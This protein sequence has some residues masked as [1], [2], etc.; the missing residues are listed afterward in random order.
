MSNDVVQRIRQAHL[1]TRMS[2][3]F[4]RDRMDAMDILR[5]HCDD[6]ELNQKI[7][8][9]CVQVIRLRILG[10][11]SFLCKAWRNLPENPPKMS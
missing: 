4:A 3:M 7:I 8:F 11:Y 10:R 2:D 1:L 6:H 9:T 5:N